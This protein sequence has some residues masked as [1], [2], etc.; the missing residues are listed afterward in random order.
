MNPNDL[1]DFS[2]DTSDTVIR[3]S[4]VSND[5][6]RILVVGTIPEQGVPMVGIQVD[7]VSIQGSMDTMASLEEALSDILMDMDDQ[8]MSLPLTPCKACGGRAKIGEVTSDKWKGVR[9]DVTCVGCGLYT[10]PY[11]WKSDASYAWRDGQYLDPKEVVLKPCLYCGKEPEV[12]HGI[13]MW[14]ARCGCPGMSVARGDER[15]ARM[16]WN[17]LVTEYTRRR[18]DLYRPQDARSSVSPDQ[19]DEGR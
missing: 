15:N 2:G 19:R 12:T 10:K 1:A 7:A 17:S 4:I 6:H 14:Y 8:L 9:Y 13:G 11:I 16:T 18:H 5:G 3:R